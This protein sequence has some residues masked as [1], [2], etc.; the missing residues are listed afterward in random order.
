MDAPLPKAAEALLRARF[1]V[2]FTGAGVSAES[3]IPTFRGAGGLWERYRAEDLATPEAFARDPKLVWE[4]YRWRQT[5]AYNAR[6][7]PAHYA[8][9]QLEEAGLVKAVITQNVDGLHQRAGSRRVVEL[10]GSLWRARCVQCGAVYKLEKPV[11]ETPPRCPRCR[12]LLRPDVVWFGEP[13]P[14]EAWEEAVQLASSA[15]VV[16]VVGTSGAVYPAA[17]IPQ[18]AKRRG[19]A[20]VEVNVE[21]SAL[22]AIADVFIRGKAGEVLPALVEEVRRGLGT[23]RV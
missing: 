13:L 9:A 22:T 20:V 23:R 7:N 11:E 14:R 12:G 21:K 4:W 10:H 19:A 2:V 17:A 5:L 1:C 16:L 6:P 18:I 3:G 15:D 8:I